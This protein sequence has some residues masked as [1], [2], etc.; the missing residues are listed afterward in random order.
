MLVWI[1]VAVIGLNIA[2]NMEFLA[3]VTL[4]PDFIII[5]LLYFVLT[6]FLYGSI[7]AGIGAVVGS[8]QESR[9]YAG[10]VSFFVGVPFFFFTLLIF[11]PESPILAGLMMFPMT[12]G[13]TYMMRFPFSSIQLWQIT[14]SLAILAVTTLTVTWFSA[15]VFRW[16]LLLYGKKPNLMTIWRVIRGTPDIGT[17]PENAVNKEQL[18]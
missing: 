13:M 2:G 14:L 8:E 3:G 17:M 1:V 15:K 18:A 16:A 7:L 11:D 5:I 9:T 4:P 12:A 10:I 6:Y